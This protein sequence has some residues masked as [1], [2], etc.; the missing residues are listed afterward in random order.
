MPKISSPIQ[1]GHV[2]AIIGYDDNQRCWIIRNSGGSGWGE[3]GYFRIS[4]DAF[5]QYYSFIYP[6]YGGT[7]ILYI[8]GIYGNLKPD[9]PKIEIVT[10]KIFHTYIFNKEIKTLF[11]QISNIQRGA[12]RILGNLTITVN[13]SNTDKVEFYVDGAFEY[14]DEEAPFNWNLNVPKGFHIVETIAY[15]NK[16]ISKDVIDVFVM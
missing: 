7:G 14:I 15:N 5:D 2:V 1:R 13:T 12:A 16:S 9:V 3:N 6:F 4:Y 11:K 8:N 10:P